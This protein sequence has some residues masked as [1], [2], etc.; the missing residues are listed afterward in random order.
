MYQK[1]IIK[2]RTESKCF[3]HLL[4]KKLHPQEVFH[5]PK[6]KVNPFVTDDLGVEPNKH[7]M[8]FAEYLSK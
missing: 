5:D 3:D 7:T 1:L 8:N 2:V 6:Y 4:D